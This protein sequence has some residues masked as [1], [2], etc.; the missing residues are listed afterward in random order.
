MKHKSMQHVNVVHLGNL[1]RKKDDSLIKSVNKDKDTDA[2]QSNAD[3]VRGKNVSRQNTS[4]GQEVKEQTTVPGRMQKNSR[5]TGGSL[6]SEH[7]SCTASSD[8]CNN[9]VCNEDHESLN[10]AM[11]E[12][13]LTRYEAV[14][15]NI[16]DTDS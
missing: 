7:E 5:F 3:I 14:Y 6:T 1:A 10:I 9:Q 8:A 16:I 13:V 4:A 15:D 2:L 11:S 12:L